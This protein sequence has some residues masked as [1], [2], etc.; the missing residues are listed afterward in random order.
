[1]YGPDRLAAEP[2]RRKP[3]ASHFSLFQICKSQNPPLFISPVG[4]VGDEAAL[5]SSETVV[6]AA[7]ANGLATR[8]PTPRVSV[9]A[10]LYCRS[11]PLGILL[12][13]SLQLL[14]IRLLES[15]IADKTFGF[16]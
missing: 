1:M 16:G 10:M 14:N 5:L 4:P 9:L 12:E 11:P 6:S 13:P 3:C 2:R 8:L 15:G 7:N